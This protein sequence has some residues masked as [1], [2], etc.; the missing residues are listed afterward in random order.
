[1]LAGVGGDD[2]VY[3]TSYEGKAVMSN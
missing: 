3:L 2:D 1:L